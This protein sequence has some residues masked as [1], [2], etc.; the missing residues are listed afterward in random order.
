MAAP[1]TR[2]ARNREVQNEELRASELM[3]LALISSIDL[4]RSHSVFLYFSL[5]SVMMRIHS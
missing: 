3:T 1:G 4:R 5:I 2:M